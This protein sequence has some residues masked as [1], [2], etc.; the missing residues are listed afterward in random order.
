MLN[1]TLEDLF[2]QLGLKEDHDS[3]ELFIQ[4]HSPL[5]DHIP[6]CKAD[7]WTASQAEFLEQA[8]ADDSVWS[9]VVD[10]LDALFRA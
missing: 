5:P 9:N 10:Q 4:A 2:D 7:F 6:L 3:I 1:Y 8:I